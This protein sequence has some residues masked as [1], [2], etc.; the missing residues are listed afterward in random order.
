M[1]DLC[2]SVFIRA[3]EKEHLFKAGSSEKAWLYQIARNYAINKLR[4]K[5]RHR[6]LDAWAFS[7]SF[8][9][10]TSKIHIKDQRESPSGEVQK[11]DELM[12][13]YHCLDELKEEE[14]EVLLLKYIE[15][16]SRQ[17]IMNV[18]GF[19]MAL[20]KKRLYLGLKHLREK[21]DKS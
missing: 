20:I 1:E 8:Y 4:D 3:K 15:G 6:E 16:L 7:K 9:A 12:Q 11:Q 21:L 19:S 17:E 2:Q 18:T 13:L 5:I 10:T 14:R